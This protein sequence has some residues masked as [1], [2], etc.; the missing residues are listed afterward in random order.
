M[1]EKQFI[2]V[3]PQAQPANTLNQMFNFMILECKSRTAYSYV[4]LFPLPTASTLLLFPQ[5]PLF[6]L[7]RP[8]SPSVS[9]RLWPGCSPTVLFFETL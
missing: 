5:L 9:K 7:L 4:C 6:Y 8:E 3:P 2:I 1:A